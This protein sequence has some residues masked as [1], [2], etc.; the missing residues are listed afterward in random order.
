[1]LHRPL[2]VLTALLSSHGFLTAQPNV[3]GFVN[4]QIPPGYSVFSNPLIS[5]D[6]TIAGLF[7]I[8]EMPEGA[9]LYTLSSGPG[10][11]LAPDLESALLEGL[12]RKIPSELSAP[13]TLTREGSELV[14]QWTGRLQT[15]A[16]VAGPYE[17]PQQTIRSLQIPQ[18]DSARFW[19]ARV[20]APFNLAQFKA[21]LWSGGA[22]SDPVQVLNPGEGFIFFNPGARPLFHTFFGLIPQ[23]RLINPIPAGW[24]I[25]SA[26]LPATGGLSART[27]L[28][29]TP[30]DHIFVWDAGALRHFTYLGAGAWAPEEPQTRAALAFFVFA[31]K[32]VT[33]EA[34]LIAGAP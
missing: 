21:N 8:P 30:G 27:K 19:R 17:T 33:W 15:A 10:G 18:T 20:E 22:W 2:F 13:I 32:P 4:V 9:V 5:Q 29:L 23:G 11:G 34:E 16:E 12:L 6:N 7:R 3:V 14:L 1:M 31:S 24:S 25:R 28:E 26:V